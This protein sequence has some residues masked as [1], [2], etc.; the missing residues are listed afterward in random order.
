VHGNLARIRE[1]KESLTRL[2]EGWLAEMLK[3]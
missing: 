1:Y 3:I 2:I